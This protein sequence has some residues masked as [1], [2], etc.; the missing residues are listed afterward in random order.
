MGRLCMYEGSNTAY[1]AL[2]GLLSGRVEPRFN[3]I[4]LKNSKRDS[5]HHA[6]AIRLPSSIQEYDHG[7][8]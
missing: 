3:L 8:D 5:R 1:H 7:L 6:G 4:A 2:C